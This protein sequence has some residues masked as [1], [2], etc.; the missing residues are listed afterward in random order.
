MPTPNCMGANSPVKIHICVE[1]KWHTKEHQSCTYQV[2]SSNR[3][4][5]EEGGGQDRHC[6]DAGSEHTVR[7]V[8]PDAIEV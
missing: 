4:C 5:G 7:D 8:S 3:D 1:A 6:Y 2:L